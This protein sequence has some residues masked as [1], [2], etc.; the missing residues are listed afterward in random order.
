MK[1]LPLTFARSR[2][3]AALGRDIPVVANGRALTQMDDEG[4]VRIVARVSD[5]LVLGA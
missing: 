1:L 2:D 4:F 3:A 5:H